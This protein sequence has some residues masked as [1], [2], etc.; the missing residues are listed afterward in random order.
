[1]GRIGGRKDEGGFRIVELGRDLLQRE[2]GIPAGQKLKEHLA[3]KGIDISRLTAY[4]EDN[5]SAPPAS[6]CQLSGS[7]N[8]SRASSGTMMKASA[9]NG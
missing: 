9:M 6:V 7:P 1:M 5:L 8:T 3:A 4:S 2:A